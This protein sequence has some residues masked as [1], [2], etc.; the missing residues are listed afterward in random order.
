MVVPGGAEETVPVAEAV[1][2]VKVV[3]VDVEVVV[4]QGD[5]RVEDE[6]L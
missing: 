4:V 1:T 5:Q 2:E 3:Q 6:V